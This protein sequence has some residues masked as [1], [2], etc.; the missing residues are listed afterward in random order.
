MHHLTRELTNRAHA[1]RGLTFS[2]FS[3]NYSFPRSISLVPTLSV[4]MPS[5][6]L[7]VVLVQ[8]HNTSRP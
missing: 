2:T 8:P 5:S 4:G 6:T 3:F 1:R 7:R